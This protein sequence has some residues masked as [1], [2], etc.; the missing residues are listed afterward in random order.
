M[1]STRAPSVSFG[2]RRK[3]NLR[4][5]V[6]DLKTTLAGKPPQARHSQ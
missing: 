1:V 3:G 4:I 5:K 6:N 2:W